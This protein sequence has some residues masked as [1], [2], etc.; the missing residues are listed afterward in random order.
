MGIYKKE[1]K[2]LNNN[3]KWVTV[4]TKLE[5]APHDVGR[6]KR[7][8]ELERRYPNGERSFYDF[9]PTK[10]GINSKVTQVRTYFGNN[11]KVVRTLITTSNKLPKG[12]KGPRK[13]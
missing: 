11:E 13:F 8:C 7:S 2:V 4:S 5:K 9:K 12:Y 10:S 6:W 1:T 3:G